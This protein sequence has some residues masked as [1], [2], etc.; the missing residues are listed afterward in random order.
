MTS[1]MEPMA[2]PPPPPEA[3]VYDEPEMQA[4]PG[5]FTNERGNLKVRTFCKSSISL[6]SAGTRSVTRVGARRRASAGTR[7][8]LE[9]A[10]RETSAAFRRS[11]SVITR[12]DC[13][14]AALVA[15]PSPPRD[16]AD[17]CAARSCSLWRLSAGARAAPC[18]WSTPSVLG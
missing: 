4:K 2:Q 1:F 11:R 18:S 14:A 10:S 5:L 3:Q 13:G 12:A 16:A 7:V 8:A 6:W 15:R 17:P 9:R